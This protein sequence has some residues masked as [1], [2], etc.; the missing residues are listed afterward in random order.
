LEHKLIG[1]NMKLD[2]GVTENGM[3][4]TMRIIVLIIVAFILLKYLW[5][6]FVMGTVAVVSWSDVTLVLGALYA[7]VAQKFFERRD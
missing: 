4:S 5:L 7:K 1:G 3:V 6:M 2:I